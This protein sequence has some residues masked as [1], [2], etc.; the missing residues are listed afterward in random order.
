MCFLKMFTFLL[1]AFSLP[2]GFIPPDKTQPASLLDD[3]KD[4]PG[5]ACLKGVDNNDAFVNVGN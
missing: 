5:K 3:F 1:F 4:T 2:R